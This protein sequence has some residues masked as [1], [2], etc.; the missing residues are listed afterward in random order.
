[1]TNTTTP[2]TPPLPPVNAEA[3]V[4]IAPNGLE[5]SIRIKPPE[6]GG[7]NLS[8]IML[9]LFLAKNR[10]VFGVDDEL[11][12]S[13]GEKPVYHTDFVVARGIPSEN[14]ADAELIYHVETNRQLKPK[15]REDGSVDFKDL[16]TIQ[17]IKKGDLLCEK[18]PA[19]PGTAGTDVR[20]GK[21]PFIAGKDKNL[22]EGKNTV[23]DE[24][25][26]KLY[27]AVDGHVSVLGGKITILDTFVVNGN[28]SNET[29]NIDFTG[30]VV[31]RG[32]VSQGFSVK[33]T[34]DITVEGVVE[35]A[36]IKTGGVLV[37]RGGFLGG[38]SGMLEVEGNTVCRFIEGG[39]ASIKGDLETTYIM[40]AVI[41]CGGTVNLT[42]K[43]LIRGGYVSART[44]VTANFLGSPKASSANTV[45]DIGNDPFLQGQYEELSKE[46]ESHKKNIAGLEAMIGP[47][48][49]AKQAG[50]LTLD[51]IKQ[52]E[53]AVQ[54]LEGLKP[55][56]LD[57]TESLELLKSQMEALGR[58]MV[59]VKKT[60]YTGL[61][62]I[63]GSES[64]ILQT[65]HD[66]VSFYAG[67]DGITF[68]PLSN[69][70]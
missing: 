34:G 38:D 32:D 29:G 48:E 52:L 64:L 68:V 8:Q 54:L 28:V 47:M 42:G 67:Q 3:T 70:T 43:G 1:M 50:Y 30:S 16:G 2:Q 11:L 55:A 58:G 18:I 10:V 6:N 17:D 21:L 62:I 33:A 25:K 24:E 61:K 49:K 44:S 56:Y 13:L 59:N 37:I 51:K 63:I 39:Q 53:K 40:N 12:K 66:R 31:V 14:G 60:A 36:K 22:P 69:K 15:E 65:E 20:G 23:S 5:A 46:A 35:A 26:L 41:K 4:T 7:T 57:I 9:K 19:N 27:A 45:I